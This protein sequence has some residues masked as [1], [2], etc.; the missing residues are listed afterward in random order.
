MVY[1]AG[2]NGKVVRFGND[3]DSVDLYDFLKILQDEYAGDSSQLSTGLDEVIDLMTLDIEPKLVVA[4]V[5]SGLRFSRVKGLSIYSPF[6]GYSKF[7]GRSDFA[8]Y[9]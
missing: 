6:K 8:T 5:A 4:N 3:K 7:Y 2:D 1:M 9:G